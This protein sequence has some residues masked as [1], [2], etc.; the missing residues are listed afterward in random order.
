MIVFKGTGTG[1]SIFN[2]NARVELTSGEVGEVLPQITRGTDRP[3]VVRVDGQ[4][5][6]IKA[7]DIKRVI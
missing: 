4:K 5:R 1:K 3:F 7:T 2:S 6:E